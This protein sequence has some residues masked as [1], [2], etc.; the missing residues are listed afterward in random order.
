MRRGAYTTAKRLA[1]YFPGYL[2]HKTDLEVGDKL[3]QFN[4]EYRRLVFVTQSPKMYRFDSNFLS[5]RDL[6]YIYFIRHEFH[7]SM[8]Q[9]STTNGF[10]YS[11]QYQN[12]ENYVPFLFDF[13]VESVSKTEDIP[14]VGFYIRP[15]LVPDSYEYAI[16]FSKNV[17]IKI[18]L[19]ILGD[20]KFDFSQYPNI[21]DYEQTYDNIHFF[22]NITHY[23]YPKSAWFQDPFPNSLLEA[24]HCNKQIIIPTIKDR[25]HKDGI[26]DITEV[27][28][29]HTRFNPD[30]S[31]DNRHCVLKIQNFEKFYLKLFE[32]NFENKL[33]RSKYNC[34]SDWIE[35]TL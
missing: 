26:D 5:I 4:E 19:M 27:I 24:V 33:D 1:N 8:F 9:N 23:I 30:I 14:V 15:L 22:K 16:H 32:N 2:D 7:P 20:C 17:D 28:N 12:I 10:Y 6:N 18:K 11:M 31:L 21:V 35:E 29:Y 13:Q 25:I 34:F 3:R